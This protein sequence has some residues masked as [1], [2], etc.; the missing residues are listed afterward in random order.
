M[1][2]HTYLFVNVVVGIK[3][4]TLYSLGQHCHAE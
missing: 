4:R 2:L 3:L 1:Y